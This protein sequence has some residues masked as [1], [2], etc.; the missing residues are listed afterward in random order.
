MFR[1]RWREAVWLLPVP[2]LALSLLVGP[3]GGVSAADCAGRLPGLL[4]G[5]S[6]APGSHEALVDAVLLEVRL[7]RVLL[8]FMVGAALSLSGAALQSMAR[9]PLVSPD[10][11]GISSGAACGAALALSTGWVPLQLAAFLGGLSAA[12]LSW[13]LARGRR[14]LSTVALLLAGMVV[15]GLFTALLAVV[16]VVSDPFKLQSIVH[17]TM[18]NLHNAG[19]GKAASASLPVALGATVLVLR[20]WRLNVVA[21]GDDET[22][23]VGLDPD[24]EKLWVLLPAVL[25]A[26]AAT[27]VAGVIGMVGLVTPHMVRLAVGPDNRR[28]IPASALAGGSF[29][30]LV[31]DLARSVTT[32]E[33]P[34]GVFTTLLGGPLFIY[35]LKRRGAWH[36]GR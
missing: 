15:N 29:L 30:V 20:R 10:V 36:E 22:R 35:L 26:S 13:M 5:Q 32:F 6:S 27:A 17:W 25:A 23:A 8:A 28:S 19:W 31:D 4:A 2:V 7:P 34:I 3:A 24:R 18:G 9:N 12:G 11:V 16:Q 14:G 1:C 33:V 21:L